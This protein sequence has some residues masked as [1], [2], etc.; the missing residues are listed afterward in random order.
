MH[1][2]G[3]ACGRRSFGGGFRVF[4]FVRMLKFKTAFCLFRV[5][6]AGGMRAIPA[7]ENRIFEFLCKDL[8]SSIVFMVKG[9]SR[10]D[11]QTAILNA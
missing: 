11:E 5:L 1:D 3:R 8:P 7:H 10:K 9:C 2:A 4:K 6:E